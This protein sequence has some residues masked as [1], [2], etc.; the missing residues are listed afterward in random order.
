MRPLSRVLRD[1]RRSSTFL[2]NRSKYRAD[3]PAEQLSRN[4]PLRL[5]SL[6]Q[7]MLLSINPVPV[8]E[9]LTPT[10]SAVWL[11]ALT[12][13]DKTA[14]ATDG[15]ALE[16]ISQSAQGIAAH[17]KLPGVFLESATAD[18]MDFTRLGV[19]GWGFDDKAVGQAELPVFR[20]VFAVPEGVEVLAAG[21]V[22]NIVDL[23][24]QYQVW[25]TQPPQG[26]SLL[27][28]PFYF[29]A[30]QYAAG[31][32]APAD[33][34]SV[35][36]IMLSGDRRTVEVEFRPFR[37]DPESG[38]IS[39]AEDFNLD[40]T[41]QAVA[42]SAS[43]QG[44]SSG[45]Y[46]PAYASSAGAADYL[47]ITADTFYEEIL[48]LAQ[49]KQKMGYKTYVAK[50][51][52]VGTT[53]TDVLSYIQAAYN[54]DSTKPQY[55][56]LVG[57]YEN[58]PSYEIIGHPAYDDTHVWHSD[59][60]FARLNGTDVYADL[61]IGRLP[62]DTEA[63]ITT[64]VN[65]ILGY[66]CTPDMGSWYDDV[67]FAGQFQDNEGS[68]P[69][70]LL[71]DRWFMQDIHRAADYLGGDYDFWSTNPD[72]YNL[73]Y[74]VHTKRVFDSAISNTLTYKTSSYPGR[75]TPP[76]PVP[77]AWKNKADESISTVINNGVGFVLHRDHGGTGGWGSPSFSTSGV[78]SLSNGSKLPIV[79]SINCETGRFDTGDYFG[80]AWMRDTNGG[81][82]TM[83]G[84]MRISYSGYNDS[85]FV[86]VMDSMWTDF[87]NS[88]SSSRY[89]P[90]WH[91]GQLMNYAKDRVFS[92]YGSSSSTALLTARMFNV[93][94]DPEIMLRTATPAALTV[95]H[96]ASINRGNATN[97]TVTVTKGGAALAGAT[98]CISK[99]EIAD[100]WIGQ[101]NSSGTVTFTGLT[102]TDAGAYDVV[103]TERN[104]VP[105]QGTFQSY[106]SQFPT[107]ATAAAANPNS[108]AGTTSALTVLGSDDGGEAN[109]T[110]T[111]TAAT[112]PSGAAQPTY[113][114]NGT[115]AAKNTTAT[116]SKAGSYTLRATIADGY[117][118]TVTSSVSVTVNQTLT[119]ITVSP[120]SVILAVGG[121]QQFTATGKDQFGG[122][123]SPQPSFTWSS[124][125]GTIDSSGYFT[126]SAS[127]PT[128]VTATNGSIHGTANVV[129]DTHTPSVATPAAAASNPIVGTTAALS[130][131]GADME[132]ESNLTY[133]WI[134]T[135]LPPE[136][137]SPSFTVNGTNAAKN[138]TATFSK[139]GN[140][141]FQ[142]TITDAVGLWTTSTVN[143]AVQQTLTSIAVTP[144]AVTLSP[145]GTQQFL[146][147]AKDQFNNNILPAPALSWTATSGT[148]DAVGFYTA[149]PSGTSDTVRA[150][151]GA[152]ISNSAAVTIANIT[153]TVA[154]PAVISPLPIVGTTANLSVLG[155]DDG[156]EANLTYT[157]T[158][159]PANLATFSV[160]GTNAAKNTVITFSQTGT[161]LIRVT[162]A[163]AGGRNAV[164]V[165]SATISSHANAIVVTPADASLL[166]GDTQQFEAVVY[167]Q[168]G[169][170]LN[171]QPNLAWSASAG[172]INPVTGLFT[173]PSTPNFTTTITAAADGV[174]GTIEV[175]I[176]D[177]PPT[178]IL[179]SNAAVA[180]NLPGATVGTLSAV[181]PDAGETFAYLLVNDPTSK[182]EIVDDV[183]KLK[184]GESLDHEA[185][186]AVELLLRATDGGGLSFE[187]SFTIA[188]DDAAETL[189]VGAGNWTESGLTLT[190]GNDGKLH[191]YHTGTED[192]A[193]LPH[194]PALVSGVSIVGSGVG[195]TL[196][197]NYAGSFASLLLDH[198]TL[199][200]SRDDAFSAA[201]NVTVKGGRLDYDGHATAIGDL[202][203]TDD[204][205][206]LGTAIHNTTTTIA[207]GTS[208]I[209]TLVC[210]TLA[211]G[212]PPESANAASASADAGFPNIDSAASVAAQEESVPPSPAA[213]SNEMAS[214]LPVAELPEQ[215]ALRNEEPSI[216]QPMLEESL[217][218]TVHA[219]LYMATR[220]EHRSDNVFSQTSPTIERPLPPLDAA[221]TESAARANASFTGKRDVQ[222]VRHLALESFA[223]EFD[224][225]LV[226]GSDET[227][228]RPRNPDKLLQKA[229][230][231]LHARL[232]AGD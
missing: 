89:S 28:N 40:L 222:R 9:Q 67:L 147:A 175:A 190:L 164:S 129:V 121:H 110:Y 80:E 66:Q 135:T 48:P 3:K 108:V 115:N 122:N 11:D 146:A 16:M 76:S 7:R 159:L 68:T 229:V 83:T 123:L 187:K 141:T 81:A 31:G 167:D 168:F 183:L 92:G 32:N 149:P 223:S 63:Q 50:M 47:I 176:G 79:F 180:E 56:L 71:E 65:K 193:V 219:G 38:R 181:D 22:T 72:P 86:G 33:Y 189:V 111:W 212:V 96:P 143:V 82:V 198:A 157:W 137:A 186:A 165:V 134:A 85:L 117:G 192:D 208:T 10:L 211:I 4:R 54:A 228:P 174:E 26:D 195:D 163:D 166:P 118:Q 170:L 107:V 215:T 209:G 153:P 91:F 87:D 182:F 142:V 42:K 114:V 103:V 30:A 221:V 21:Q 201:T 35:G 217:G 52:Q 128:I 64:M 75:I 69:Y 218:I 188:V 200:F 179:L 133:S 84:A 49:W 169:K 59:Y 88:W 112:V 172:S 14:Y 36:D 27:T 55:V 225:C 98:V 205:Q 116:F 74:T 109:L 136:A 154:A 127:F 231:E 104:A 197:D 124:N 94:G 120:A 95:T 24:A 34:F 51:S 203:V 119:S 102:T 53:A 2:A 57:D 184:D 130:V 160:N 148:I 158:C 132:G 227:A 106:A 58:V 191:V 43:A 162:I 77:D 45:E 62:G 232:V 155:A 99:G 196:L 44:V 173:A 224:W 230:D 101:T 39:V 37:Y 194:D 202:T 25:P 29:D 178:D 12:A 113:S 140:Y 78:N 216:A 100:Y 131:L 18:G 105:Y 41:F 93:L 17:L 20:A 6:E 150:Q 138:T 220:R 156:G 226:S 171:P 5:E 8:Y 23:T 1:F 206:V 126:A 185:A 161:C 19:P 204:G 144:A 97:F 213:I 214:P 70:D 73:G 60:D 145:S 139:A 207:S 13:D 15:A 90:S 125:F 210:E 46:T 61:A 152:V 151:S 177:R 199:R